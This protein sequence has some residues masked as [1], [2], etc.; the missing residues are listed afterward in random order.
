MS[1]VSTLTISS[2]VVIAVAACT[3]PMPAGSGPGNSGPPPTTEQAAVAL[4]VS[5]LSSNSL[6]AP[7]LLR[8]FHPRAG[9]AS[10]TPEAIARDHVAALAPLWVQQAQPM[11][12]VATGSQ[13]LRN[14]AMIVKLAQQ[15]DGVVVD[16]GE[17]HV[18]MHRDGSLAAVSGT[19]L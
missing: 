16:Q 19:L 15:V 2:M 3:S 13:P 8:A 12:L 10:A 9:L 7:R 14:G 11:P 5:I 6:G 17:L 18:L 4:G 1:R